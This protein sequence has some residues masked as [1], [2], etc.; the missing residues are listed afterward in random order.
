MVKLSFYCDKSKNKEYMELCNFI[1]GD[2]NLGWWL[3]KASL[4]ELEMMFKG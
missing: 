2:P 4:K 3:T 1:T